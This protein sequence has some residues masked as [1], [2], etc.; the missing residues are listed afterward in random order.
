MFGLAEELL[1]VCRLACKQWEWA[2]KSD[3]LLHELLQVLSL[4]PWRG[5][6]VLLS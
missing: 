5:L 1:H 2:K 6:A 4:S 3:G